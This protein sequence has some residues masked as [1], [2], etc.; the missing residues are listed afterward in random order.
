MRRSLATVILLAAA[1][2]VCADPVSAVD[3]YPLA[4]LFAPPPAT[5]ADFN[6]TPRSF[7]ADVDWGTFATLSTGATER[8]T[9]DG[10]FVALTGRWLWQADG[11]RLGLDIPL[12]YQSGGLLDRLIDDFHQVFDLPEGDRPALPLDALRIRYEDANGVRFDMQN[13]GWALGEAHVHIGR[14][15]TASSTRATAW[16]AHFKLPTGNVN[17]LLGSGTFGAGLEWNGLARSS[18]WGRAVTWFA[19][20]GA[21]W[22]DGSEILP[23]RFERWA[24]FGH[25]G[26]RIA[27][28]PAL[29]A[30]VQLDAHS[31]YFQSDLDG[32]GP[33]YS[34]TFGGRWERASG[35]AFEFTVFEDIVPRSTPDVVFQFRWLRG[36]AL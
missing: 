33:G 10:E 32:L 30:V 2:P 24:A 9:F 35:D 13:T 7:V 1:V 17:R 26:M 5:V 14:S 28:R 8:L 4:R 29:S 22:H 11:W 23:D 6:A 31:S 16:R 25:A 19:G 18:L 36:A 3:R 27:L 34:I 20:A 15:L 21:Q 12:V